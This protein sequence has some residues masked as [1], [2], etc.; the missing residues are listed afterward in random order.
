VSA[1]PFTSHVDDDAAVNWSDDLEE[2]H[3]ESTRSHFIDRWTR[4]AI[5]ARIG[6]L[7]PSPVVLDAG[8]STGHLLRDLDAD[9]P[10]AELIGVD[11]VASGLRKAHEAVPRARLMRADVCALPLDDASVDVVVSAN[12]LEHVPDDRGALRE[13]NRVLRPGGRAVL[14][15]PAG[16]R[17]YD[18]YDRFLGHERRYAR[19]ELGTKA[20]D[21]GLDVLEQR[22]IGALLYPPFAAVKA[23]NRLLRH[24]LEGAALEE[25]VARDI[26][27]TQDSRVGNALWRAEEALRRTGVRLPFGI[28]WLVV[29]RRPVS[30]VA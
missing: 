19:R 23:R 1:E 15:V 14:V 28:R 6:E 21:A 10:A 30:V 17:S 27:A 16:P 29:A 24:G 11:L 20:S 4:S 7:P 8:C 3:E 26:A 5:I 13:I 25:Q 18:Y 2:L 12:L 22:S 9:L